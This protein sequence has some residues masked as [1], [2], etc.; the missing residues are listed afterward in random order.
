MGEQSYLKR[1]GVGERV[2]K[3]MK[4]F[5]A[6]ILFAA[7]LIVV[8]GAVALER[9]HSWKGQIQLDQYLAGMRS[10]A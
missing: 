4:M 9:H 7:V 8:A 6:V 10:R 3:D 1:K 2:M 5:A